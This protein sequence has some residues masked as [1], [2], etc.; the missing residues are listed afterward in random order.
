MNK[1]LMSNGNTCNYSTVCKQI[2]SD[3]L[4]KMVSFSINL[5]KNCIYIYIYIYIY[6]FIL[7]SF[8]K[9]TTS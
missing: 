2:S 6:M 7:I 3:D 8:S 1:I 4:F 5:P 9:E